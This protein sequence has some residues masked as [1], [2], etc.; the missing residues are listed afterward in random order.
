MGRGERDPQAR[1]RSRSVP[2]PVPQL[3]IGG[4][5]LPEPEDTDTSLDPSVLGPGLRRDPSFPLG[6]TRLRS[7]VLIG[8]LCDIS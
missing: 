7:T 2:S 4:G 1:V 5:G 6:S 3:S 8:L